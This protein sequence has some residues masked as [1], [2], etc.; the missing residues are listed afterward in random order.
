MPRY[1][2]E[3]NWIPS[4]RYSPTPQTLQTDMERHKLLCV[5]TSYDKPHLSMRESLFWWCG[6]QKSIENFKWMFCWVHVKLHHWTRGFDKLVVCWRKKDSKS[7][8]HPNKAPFLQIPEIDEKLGLESMKKKLMLRFVHG[9]LNVHSVWN[10][11]TS[12]HISTV[13]WVWRPL[14]HFKTCM[15]LAMWLCK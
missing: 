14:T 2:C 5:H 12:W 11:N 6:W 3:I 1:F 15:W 7:E 10:W 8:R 13:V 9:S 4:F